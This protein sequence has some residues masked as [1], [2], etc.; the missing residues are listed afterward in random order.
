M[1]QTTLQAILFDNNYYNSDKARKWLKKNGY[2]PIK[3]V[4]KTE[5]YLR[6][7][8]K[9]PNKKKKYRTI[10]LGYKIKAIIEINNLKG[11]GS[12]YQK[13][14]ETGQYCR[15]RHWNPTSNY[16]WY[17]YTAKSENPHKYYFP[18]GFVYADK[19]K[20]IKIRSWPYKTYRKNCRSK[21]ISDLW[22]KVDEYGQPL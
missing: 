6:Y 8:L 19:D 9:K 22:K 3:R 14:M 7:R 1:K 15:K 21:K 10:K 11:S 12:G 5:N 13:K 4:H 2:K 17:D 18:D 20:K 16:L